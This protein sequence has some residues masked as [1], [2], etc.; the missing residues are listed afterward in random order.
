MVP[1]PKWVE[2]LKQE[3]VIVFGVLKLFL[4]VLYAL[5]LSVKILQTLLNWG[6]LLFLFY[7]VLGTQK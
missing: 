1:F 3:E 6:T 4:L 7:P 5:S 2:N